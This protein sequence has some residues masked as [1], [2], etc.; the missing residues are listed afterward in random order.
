M[1]LF[2]TYTFG[3]ILNRDDVFTAIRDMAENRGCKWMEDKLQAV[4][5]MASG[6]NN[7]YLSRKGNLR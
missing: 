4:P 2:Q 1:F 3:A 7:W 5:T 6:K